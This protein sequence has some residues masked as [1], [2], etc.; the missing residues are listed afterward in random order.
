MFWTLK[1]LWGMRR[2]LVIV[3]ISIVI[4]FVFSIVI[5]SVWVVY[6]AQENFRTGEKYRGGLGVP[7]DYSEAFKWY[8]KAAEQEHAGAQFN[9]GLMYYKGE[10]I[11]KDDSKA[12]MWYHNAAGQGIVQAQY[13][14][15]V[16]LSLIHI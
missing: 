3:I 7:K 13:N 14:L 2:I 11:P 8:H 4:G 6:E 15:G 12:L 5:H 10:G 9:V 1:G 16:M